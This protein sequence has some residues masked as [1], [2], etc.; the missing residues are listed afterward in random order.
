MGRIP[1]DNVSLLLQRDT[2]L[3]LFISGDANIRK[4]PLH[5][6]YKDH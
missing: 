3:P 4:I 6:F 2:A 5:K 1:L